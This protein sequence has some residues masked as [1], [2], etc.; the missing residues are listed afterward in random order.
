MSKFKL[1]VKCNLFVLPICFIMNM[2]VGWYF[3]GMISRNAASVAESLANLQCVSD[4]QLES[5]INELEKSQLYVLDLMRVCIFLLY[6]FVMTACCLVE[7]KL[8]KSQ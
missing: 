5:L 1:T 2:Y 8:R 4:G 7:M 3:P 6:I